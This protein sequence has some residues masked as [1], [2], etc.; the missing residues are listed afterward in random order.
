[1]LNHNPKT[2]GYLL[3]QFLQLGDVPL[4]TASPKFLY[5]LFIL[6]QHYMSIAEKNPVV[7]VL[8]GFPWEGQYLI[9]F[10]ISLCS[11]CVSLCV[12]MC[13]HVRIHTSSSLFYGALH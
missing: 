12:C 4:M 10:D 1:M 7:N 2:Q 5:S 3:N 8:V 6:A 11:V 9:G 13:V